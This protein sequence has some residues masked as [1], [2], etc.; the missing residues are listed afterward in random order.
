MP[1]EPRTLYRAKIDII[2]TTA[3]VGKPGALPYRA[4]L[5]IVDT[6]TA[7]S[8]E[9]FHTLPSTTDFRSSY[10]KAL[11]TLAELIS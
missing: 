6:R 8:H 7:N 11:E 10:T 9:L 1:L 3:D 2:E 4:N 5:T